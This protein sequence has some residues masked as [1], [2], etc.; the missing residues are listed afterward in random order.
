MVWT[1]SHKK[2]KKWANVATRIS[3]EMKA[4]LEMLAE[5]AGLTTSAYLATLIKADI[6]DAFTPA[7]ET[8]EHSDLGCLIVRRRAKRRENITLEGPPCET[9]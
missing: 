2:P 1:P 4:E 8:R 3:V 6:D 7:T 5:Q 9:E